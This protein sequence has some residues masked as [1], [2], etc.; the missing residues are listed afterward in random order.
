MFEVLFFEKKFFKFFKILMWVGVLIVICMK[1]DLVELL[2][3]WEEIVVV[4]MVVQNIWFIVIV[5]GFGGYW[6]LLG[7][8]KYL[9]EF[10][11]L[12][13]GECCFGLFYL[14]YY[15]VLEILCE[16]GVIVDKVEWMCE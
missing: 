10:F 7:I 1:C 15:K 12:E 11:G 16:C 5:Y 2:F 9:G 8:V 14:V 4:V 3:E 13:D 6:F